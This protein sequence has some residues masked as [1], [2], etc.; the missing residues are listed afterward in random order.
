MR[1][2]SISPEKKKINSAK[3]LYFKIQQL[4][5][6]ACE[7]GLFETRKLLNDAM[8]KAGWEMANLIE[9]FTK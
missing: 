2:R 8:N 9:N 6:V 7:I 3:D 4:E 5:I 1:Y